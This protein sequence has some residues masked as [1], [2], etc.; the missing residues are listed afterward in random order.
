[1]NSEISDNVLIV[2]FFK[3]RAFNAAGFEA[4]N[5]EKAGP[6]WS[7]L[8]YS[9]TSL[10]AVI[11]G[12]TGVYATGRILDATNQDWTLVFS[13]NAGMNVLGAIAFLA[14]FDSKREFD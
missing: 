4:G 9:V 10:P 11:V 1:M 6:K 2:Y 5:Q 13:L 7:G 8:L 12:T 14:L 3:C